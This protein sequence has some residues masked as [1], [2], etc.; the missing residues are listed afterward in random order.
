MFFTCIAAVGKNALCGFVWICVF[1]RRRIWICWNGWLWRMDTSN[2]SITMTSIPFHVTDWN[3]RRFF[4]QLIE[5][6]IRISHLVLLFACIVWK[7]RVN[8]RI[9]WTSRNRMWQC[10]HSNATHLYW[11]KNFDWFM[12]AVNS[13]RSLKSRWKHVCDS[14]QIIRWFRTLLSVMKFS[15]QFSTNGCP[16]SARCFIANNFQSKCQCMHTKFGLNE[17]QQLWT[18]N[19]F[20]WHLSAHFSQCFS[21]FCVH[22]VHTIYFC[23]FS[24][25]ET[26]SHWMA[27]LF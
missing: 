12:L 21:H 18:L 22:T 20:L 2:K 25:T 8:I 27:F 16:L 15:T 9:C 3:S 6:E 10:V 23:Q 1:C 17:W 13:M 14:R 26:S 4:S 19:A 7:A 5:I 11:L 24:W